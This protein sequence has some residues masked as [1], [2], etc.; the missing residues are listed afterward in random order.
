MDVVRAVRSTFIAALSVGALVVLAPGCGGGEGEG[1]STGTASAQPTSPSAQQTVTPGQPRS[2]TVDVG[3]EV[4]D[5]L[6]R[7]ESQDAKVV[8][9]L[10]SRRGDEVD[11]GSLILYWR[12]PDWRVD[13]QSASELAS[14]VQRGNQ[15][16]VCM[17][18]SRRCTRVP[19]LGPLPAPLPFLFVRPSDVA[20]LVRERLVERVSGVEVERSARRLAGEETTCFSVRGGAVE[21]AE[22]EVCWSGDGIL[23]Y[24]SAEVTPAA[25]GAFRT[26]MEATGVERGVSEQDVQPPYRIE[27]LPFG[28]PTQAGP[29]P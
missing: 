29:G 26:T 21:T 7:W 20:A 18:A 3:R 24:L 12:P 9:R 1:P 17:E 14:V 15:L 10:T 22:I 2:P 13:F 27:E 16:Y 5:L 28:V 11:E 25:G 6:R 19:L 4:E 8:Y 23:L